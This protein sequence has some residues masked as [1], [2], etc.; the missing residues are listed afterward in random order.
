[1]PKFNSI[2]NYQGDLSSNYTV[3]SLVDKGY[4]DGLVAGGVT[5]IGG[6]DAATN[7]PDLVSG[8]GIVTGDMYTVTVAGTFF[9]IPVEPGDVLIAQQDTPTL[10]TNWTYVEKGGDYLQGSGTNNYVARFTPDGITLGDSLIQDDGTTIGINAIPV[11][12][13]HI[14]AENSTEN[15]FIHRNTLG[16]YA[17]TG[18]TVGASAISG[19]SIG[20]SGSGSG[21]PVNFGGTFGATGATGIFGTG[22]SAVASITGATRNVGIYGQALNGTDNYSAWLRDGTEGTGKFLKSVSSDGKANWANIT[23]S[24][25]SGVVGG[26]GTSDQVAYFTATGTISS[27]PDFLFNGSTISIGGALNASYK[28]N[29]ES[30]SGTIG[31]RSNV[32]N[33]GGTGV[34]GISTGTGTSANIGSFGFASNS[35]VLNIGVRGDATATTAG[36]NIGGYFFANGGANNYALQLIDGSQA[37]GKFLKSITSNGE[38]NWA[39]IT[40]S[41]V[42]GV[43]GGSGTAN[44]VAYFTA[45]GTISS[46]PI[47]LFNGSTIGINTLNP[48]SWLNIEGSTLSNGIRSIN[49]FTA[50]TAKGALFAAQGV[51]ANSNVGI[52]ASAQGSTSENIAGSFA[53]SGTNPY[54]IQLVDGSEGAGKVLTSDASG[55]ATWQTPTSGGATELDDLSDV[56]TGL[57]VTPTAVDDGRMLFYDFDTGQWISD[58]TVNHGTVII[59][60]YSGEGVAIDKGTPVYLTGNFANDAHEVGIAD[61]DDPAKMPVIG[62]AAESIPTASTNAKHVCTFGKLQGIDTTST[63]AIANG[64]SWTAGDIL[65]MSTTPG[66]LTLNRPTGASTGIQR[67]AQVLR[68]DATGGQIFIFNTAR[69][70]GLPNLSTDNLWVGDG[71]NLPQEAGVNTVGIYSGSGTIPTT[72]LASLTDNLVFGSGNL[73]RID[74]TNGVIGIKSTDITGT[75]NISDDKLY[76][77]YVENT[78]TASTAYGARFDLITANTQE[79]KGILISTLNGRNNIGIDIGGGIGFGSNTDIGYLANLSSSTT[80]AVNQYGSYLRMSST[81]TAWGN[82]YGLFVNSS[83]TQTVSK[84]ATYGVRVDMQDDMSLGGTSYGSYIRQ[85]SNAASANYGIYAQISGTSPSSY[86]ARILNTNTGSFNYGQFIQVSGATSQNIGQQISLTGST[87]TN[88][89]LVSQATGVV[90]QNIGGRFFADN[91]TA[92]NVAIEALAGATSATATSGD[93]AITAQVKSNTLPS[94][95]NIWVRNESQSPTADGIFIDDTFAAPTILSGTRRGARISM[96]QAATTNTGILVSVQNASSS[97]V[98]IQTNQGDNLFNATSGTTD[99]QGGLARTGSSTIPAGTTTLTPGEFSVMKI[100]NNGTAVSATLANGV[101]G[102]RLTIYVL[103]AG[104]PTLG[105]TAISPTT[106][107]GYTSITL[108]KPGESVDLLYD[109]S[110]GWVIVGSYDATIA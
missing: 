104:S 82:K 26:S 93:V 47:F 110:I 79:N 90:N 61:A 10:E 32:T 29:V 56:T 23:A 95:R 39:N 106:A 78:Q 107:A 17:V 52:Q 76:G 62:F 44:Q 3:R 77:I 50:G 55:K 19:Q 2:V 97:N 59:N 27:D 49:T 54:A 64:Q 83:G 89:G 68:V 58:D 102:Q 98:A 28:L 36:D 13:T 109:N 38:A 11:S 33:N 48:S 69:T 88:I 70:A 34:Y 25:V 73:L 51:N 101:D 103:S 7:T 8:T 65:Y 16:G 45:S 57:P 92:Y 42:S 31:I 63:G 46:D 18:T 87:G 94:S 21:S 9:T 20:V 30:S 91:A 37:I 12:N 24:D 35:S 60:T 105:S 22:V 53:A 71:N 96:T 84:T 5:Y 66:V 6:Y 85:I 99:F 67:I 41:D 80:S 15:G 72:T 86:G 4:V 40:A 75:L 43:V 1:M 14:Y 81:A 108:S 100:Q 74:E